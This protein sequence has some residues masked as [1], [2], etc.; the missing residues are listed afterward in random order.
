MEEQLATNAFKFEEDYK[1][2]YIDPPFIPEV[3]SAPNRMLLL[4]SHS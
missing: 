1:V 2:E 4:L 3:P